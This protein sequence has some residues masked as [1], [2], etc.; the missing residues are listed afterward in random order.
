MKRIGLV[1]LILICF[2]TACTNTNTN[3]A[4][5]DH[6][7]EP[8]EASPYNLAVKHSDSSS[9]NEEATATHDEITSID[10][11]EATPTNSEEA[12]LFLEKASAK[13]Y[14]LETVTFTSV[15]FNTG[16]FR[17]LDDNYNTF[18]EYRKTLDGTIQRQP[19]LAYIVETSDD[20]YG[21]ISDE[22]DYIYEESSRRTVAY[23][24]YFDEA[25]GHFSQSNFYSYGDVVEESSGE[26]YH[27]ELDYRFRTL[28]HLEA[29][30]HL[31]MSYP[32]QLSMFTYREG[33]EGDRTELMHIELELSQEQYMN[34]ILM[35]ENNIFSGV[36]LDQEN[37]EALYYVES[38]K[39]K[40]LSLSLT[41]DHDYNLTYISVNHTTNALEDYIGENR[42]DTFTTYYST[43][44]FDHNKPYPYTIPNDVILNAQYE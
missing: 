36:Y 23:T 22:E 27:D 15:A 18:S 5:I 35:L 29:F 30:I 17:N 26:I 19:K 43:Y 42:D 12:L 33:E 7:L 38:E 10:G 28:E 24:H 25:L 34:H 6:E 41:F 21:E 37:E 1:A 16:I 40:N 13:I 20:V 39:L 4:N 8:T 9:V 2:M 14:E 11:E 3:K 32:D 31:F 44:F